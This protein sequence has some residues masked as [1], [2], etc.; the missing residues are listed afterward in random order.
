MYISAVG[1]VRKLKFNSCVNLPSI[2]QIF[3]YP[4][5]PVILHCN[6]VREVYI[7]EH[8][9][10]ISAL[11]NYIKIKFSKYVHQVLVYSNYDF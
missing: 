8:G 6:S 1:L 11:K 7:L 2:Y 3:Q 5:T 4:Q 10:Y 9:L